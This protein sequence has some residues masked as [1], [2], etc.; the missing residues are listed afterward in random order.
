M[1]KFA[2]GL[3]LLSFVFALAC[4]SSDTGTRVGDKESRWVS[5]IVYR[6]KDSKPTAKVFPKFLRLIHQKHKL[7]F[8]VYNN[9]E[10]GLD[11]KSV[12]VDFGANAPFD[13]NQKKYMI[14]NVASGFSSDLEMKLAK[15]VGGNTVTYDYTVNVTLSDGTTIVADP[16]VEISGGRVNVQTR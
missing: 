9:L 2:C 13:D 1:R 6:E 12:D 14:S 4:T 8:I 16:Q 10:E 5:I 7:H 11:I 3:L 15:D